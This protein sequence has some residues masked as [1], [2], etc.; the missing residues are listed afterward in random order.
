MPCLLRA[1]NAP[2]YVYGWVS[3][4]TPLGE[5]TALPRPPAGFGKMREGERGRGEGKVRPPSKNPIPGYG[6]LICYS[7]FHSHQTTS[8]YVFC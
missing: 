6:L 4:Q 8:A 3:A 7:R 1:V 5:L 2:K